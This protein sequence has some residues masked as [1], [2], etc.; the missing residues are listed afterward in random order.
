MVIKYFPP[1]LD[2]GELIEFLIESGIPAEKKDLININDRGVVTV[3]DL[4]NETCLL[5]V[6]NLHGK[7]HFSKIIYC[8][9]IVP[10]TPEKG[11][12]KEMIRFA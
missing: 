8:N 7:R 2:H 10:L 11:S 1:E 4:D 6:S 3:R 9:G 12:F 5:L